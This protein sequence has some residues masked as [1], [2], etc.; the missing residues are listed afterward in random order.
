[1]KETGG[2]TIFS[3][4]YIKVDPTKRYRLSG[5]FKSVGVGGLSRVYFGYE[6]W[7][8]KFRQF[9]C[10]MADHFV[11]TKTTLAQPLNTGDSIVYLN[12]VAN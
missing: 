2:S 10:H 7:D 8:K 9:I 4:N 11:S 3:S 5:C 6:S 12:S 1:L